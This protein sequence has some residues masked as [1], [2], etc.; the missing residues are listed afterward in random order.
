M[1]GT[2]SAE[3]LGDVRRYCQ[4][5]IEASQGLEDSNL[6]LSV[7]S[8]VQLLHLRTSWKVNSANFALTEL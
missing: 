2:G 3:E 8:G 5:C 1:S 6:P 7:P 4:G